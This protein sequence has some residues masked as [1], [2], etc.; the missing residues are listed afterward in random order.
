MNPVVK[1]ISQVIVLI[2]RQIDKLERNT[3]EKIKQSFFFSI[4][5]LVIFGIFTG[6]HYGKDAAK[7][8][9]DPLI[10]YTND[11]FDTTIKMGRDETQ[12]QAMLENELFSERDI[13]KLNKITFP[14][15]ERLKSQHRYNNEIIEPDTSSS[16]MSIP[17]LDT[18]DRIAEIDRTDKKYKS[19][20][21]KELGRRSHTK[22]DRE[23]LG[24]IKDDKDKISIDGL[25]D[26]SRESWKHKETVKKEIPLK[27][28]VR[29][30]GVVER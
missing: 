22:E 21:V 8:Y 27:P 20:V 26:G 1:I 4:F 9:G 30:T 29:D 13:S 19:G 15:N 17:G 14:S 28:I 12:F 2:N 5:I 6:Y 24:I 7:R 10:K 3:V 25:Y 23:K 18:R 16:K 11:V